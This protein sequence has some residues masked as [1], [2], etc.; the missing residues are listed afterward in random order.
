MKNK[1]QKINHKKKKKKKNKNKN[2]QRP[3]W[4]SIDWENEHSL[5]QRAYARDVIFVIYRKETTKGLRSK[6]H[7]RNL[8]WCDL[9]S[10]IILGTANNRQAEK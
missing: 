1:N 10:Y 5:C 3:L 6:R 7:L 9:C 4:A 2:G 8:L